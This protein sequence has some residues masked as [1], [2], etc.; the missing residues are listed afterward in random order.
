MAGEWIKVQCSTPD[1]PEV[2]RIARELCI[3]RDAVFGKLMLLWM[4]FD[5]N[6]VDGV[7]DGAV[8]GDVDALVRYAG[9]ADVMRKVGWL[10]DTADGPGLYLP[11]FDRH[12]GETAKRRA[13][14]N[15]RQAKWRNAP[16]D[17]RVDGPR[18]TNAST[19][20]EKRRSKTPLP[21]FGGFAVPVW[22]P[23]ETWKAFE[24]HRNKKRSPMTPEARRLIVLELEKLDPTHANARALLEQSIR[25]GWL[26]VFPLKKGDQAQQ[27]MTVDL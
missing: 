19:R 2:L 14:S 16:V 20:E 8:D 3:D 1:K 26:D 15:R 18:V 4:W 22:I 25:K 23:N 24:E 13:L 21:P 5:R 27:R 12:N 9:F 6:S 11:N 7:V 17:A 10:K